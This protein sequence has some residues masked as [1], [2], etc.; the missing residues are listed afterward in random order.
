MVV[1]SIRASFDDANAPAAARAN[2]L[3]S[4]G[5]DRVPI[6]RGSL[7]SALCEGGFCPQNC[8]MANRATI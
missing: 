8:T 4:R 1:V 7:P 6:P 5:A 2:M 3:R